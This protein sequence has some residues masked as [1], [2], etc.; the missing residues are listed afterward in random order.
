MYYSTRGIFLR[1][2]KYSETSVIAGIYTEEFGL[3]SYIIKNARSKKSRI[4]PGLLQPLVLLDMVVSHREKANLNYIKEMRNGCLVDSLLTD[5]RKS[6]VILFLD[7][8]LIKT[9]QEE[10]KN[11]ELFNFIFESVRLL[12]SM[13]GSISLFHLVFALKL[14]KYLGFYPQGSCS[15]ANNSFDMEE[16]SFTGDPGIEKPIYLRGD[17][18][19][20]FALLMN[21]TYEEIG[22][23]RIKPATKKALLEKILL[24]YSLHIPTAVNFKSHNVLQEVFR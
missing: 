4:S 20:Q 16:G 7:E 3:Q 17:V 12:D 24:F 15:P 18:C 10:N 2:V 13:E 19:E 21:L 22:S 6:A 23:H 1:K 8:L 9:I 5:I 11:P 14:T